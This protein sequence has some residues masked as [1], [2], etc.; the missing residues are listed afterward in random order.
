MVKYVRPNI[1]RVES[2]GNIREID[3]WSVPVNHNVANLYT[4]ALHRPV[5]DPEGV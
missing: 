3:T 5:A 1:T 4:A 2:Y